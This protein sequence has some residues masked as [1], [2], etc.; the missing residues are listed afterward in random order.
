MPKSS[1][2]S[3]LTKKVIYILIFPNGKINVG[4]DLTDDICYFGSANAEVVALDFMP[5]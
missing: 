5:N 3:K 2:R 4:S 1:K